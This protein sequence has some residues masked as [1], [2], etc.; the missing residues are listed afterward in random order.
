VGIPEAEDVFYSLYSPD[1]PYPA[2]LEFIEID[3]WENVVNGNSYTSRLEPLLIGLHRNPQTED[4]P[5]VYIGQADD[6]TYYGYEFNTTLNTI[7]EINLASLMNQVGDSNYLS[8]LQLDQPGTR[9]SYKLKQI[10][11]C[12]RRPPPG[13]FEKAERV[14]RGYDHFADNDTSV[15]ML[16][17]II[18]KTLI[19]IHTRYTTGTWPMDGWNQSRNATP[20][21]SYP[22]LKESCVRLWEFL[23]KI[24]P[25]ADW[26]GYDGSLLE[27]AVLRCKMYV[28]WDDNIMNWLFVFFAA[29]SGMES[30]QT[31]IVRQ[32]SL[33]PKAEM[34][35]IRDIEFDFDRVLEALPPTDRVHQPAVDITIVH[36]DGMATGR[37]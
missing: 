2:N 3:K 1:Y 12:P 9:H 27:K 14:V 33:D 30:L 26:N 29:R 4:S 36:R 34:E 7:T 13:L 31:T 6:F 18:S 23:Q 25:K 32:R 8:T 10:R 24:R 28:E 35:A 19:G 15:A 11:K 22:I 16:Q 37:N 21:D 20:I 5:W 17:T